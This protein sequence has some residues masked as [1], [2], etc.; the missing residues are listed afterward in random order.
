[1]KRRQF[2]K[3]LSG[4]AALAVPVGLAANGLRKHRAGN[5]ATE[6]KAPDQLTVEQLRAVVRKLKDNKAVT[7]Q[8]DHWESD[9]VAFGR[10]EDSFLV[11][12]KVARLK[13]TKVMPPRGRWSA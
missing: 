1:M 6:G 5:V 3:A 7:V 13:S 10:P 8:G 4:V 12:Q 11:P 2:I 9:Y